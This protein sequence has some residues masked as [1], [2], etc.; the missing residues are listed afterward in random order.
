MP[1]KNTRWLPLGLWYLLFATSVDAVVVPERSSLAAEKAFQHEDLSIS[2]VFQDPDRL[3]PAVR[4]QAMQALATLG[5][6]SQNARIDSRGGRWAMLLPTEPLLPGTGV[7]NDLRWSA[8]EKEPPQ[9]L[10][11]LE[12]A[13]WSAFVGYLEVH[14]GALHIDPTEATKGRVTAHGGGELIQIYAPR[15]VDGIE[16]RDSY[17]TAVIGHGN[18]MLFGAHR[19]GDTP[20]PPRSTISVEEANQAAQRYLY[21][22]N[23]DGDSA[24]P[25]L[26][27]VPIAAGQRYGHRLVWVLH[28][29]VPGDPG[30]WEL[31]ID[32]QSGEVMSF[33][34]TNS[35][36][37]TARKAKGGVF[38]VTNTGAV[39]EGVEQAGW[40]LPF[41]EVSTPSGARITDTGGNLPGAIDGNISAGLDGPFVKTND[42]CGVSR[43][44]RAGDLDFGTSG[45][46]DCTTP[47]LGGAGNTHASRTAFYELN[48]IIEIA[49]G[50]LPTNPWLQQQLTANVNEILVHCQASW[51]GSTVNFYRS[52]GGCANTGEFV[53]ILDHEWGHGMDDNDALPTIAGPSGEGIADL[54]AAL[55]LDDSCI[56]RGVLGSPCGGYGDPCLSCSGYRDID[57]EQRQSGQP[58]DYSWANANC[59]SITHCIGAVYSEAVWSLW[60]RQLT[61][62][63]F[64]MDNNTAA[65]VVSRL[66]F[67]G[68]GA[69]GTWFS[70]GP[71]YGGCAATSGYLSY[72]AADDTNGSLADG[73]PHMSAIFAAFDDQE[74]ACD[75]PAVQNSGCGNRPMVA[76]VVTASPFVQSLQLTWGAVPN[77]SKYQVFRTEGV[78]ACDF[79]K[80]KLGE[81]TGTEWTDHGLQTGRQYAYIVIPIGTADACFGPA[82]S[83]TI[84]STHEGRFEVGAHISNQVLR[85]QSYFPYVNPRVITGPPSFAGADPTP[86]RVRNVTPTSF[87]QNSPEWDYLDNIHPVETLG[88]LVIEDG[89]QLMGSLAAEAGLA[90]IDHQWA[91]V[92]F[93]QTF[94][95]VPVVFSQVTS[96][97]ESQAVTARVR[98]VTT[99]GFQI[100]LQEEEG[101]NGSHA[102]ERVDWVAVETGLTRLPS[103]RKL[104]VGRTGNSVT[105]NWSTLRFSR[106]AQPMIVAD[107]QTYDESD[108]AVLRYRNLTTSSVQVKIEEERSSDSEVSHATEVVGYLIG[109]KIF[110]LP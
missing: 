27:W 88:F 76:P 101:N 35:Y 30:R 57:Y 89:P 95:T 16:V 86:V 53:G 20:A 26:Q 108:P 17:L 28:P 96:F 44:I 24:G 85:T 19:W 79:G 25:Y 34:D 55:R 18:L 21:P 67:L 15:R 97:A 36:A 13:A 14:R 33:Q 81:T 2:R 9:N 48:K 93:R 100:K 10:A 31:M 87:Q 42:R 1:R 78:L 94:A 102:N 110:G 5:I 40:P 7:G 63:P 64:H 106:I 23:A 105:H 37:A 80:V 104:V 109:D 39:P 12:R 103:G 60:K 43:L 32:A 6:A 59:G 77:A 58:H 4:T 70:G 3:G 91:T 61:A 75:T 72:L 46:T 98:N 65:E 8:M 69:T 73:T 82:S 38:P 62:A 54:Y 52:G 74:I 92:S 84:A 22:W 66:T 29:H 50:H 90:H 47:G 51:N 99:S 107:L 41:L 11:A 68:A 71:P 56:G 83:C 45:G 49:K